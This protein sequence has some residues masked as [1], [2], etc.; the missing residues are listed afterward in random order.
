MEEISVLVVDD[1]RAHL[2]WISTTLGS[3][4]NRQNEYKLSIDTRYDA[5]LV[6]EEIDKGDFP[7]GIVIADVMMP[8]AKDGAFLIY[9]ALKRNRERYPDTF[10]MSITTERNTMSGVPEWR[11]ID[12]EQRI[13]G[14]EAWHI[15]FA[16]ADYFS[17]NDHSCLY[18]KDRWIYILYDAVTKYNNTLWRKSFL[19]ET[20]YTN[21]TST[22]WRELIYEAQ[23]IANENE[24]VV[25]LTGKPGV[26]REYLAKII[27]KS[28]KQWSAGGFV[29][30]NVASLPL[31]FVEDNLFGASGDFTVPSLL[32]SAAGGTLYLGNVNCDNESASVIRNVVDRVRNSQ[33]MQDGLPGAVILSTS[34][35]KELPDPLRNMRVCLIE[36]PALDDRREEIPELVQHINNE[37]AA[38]GIGDNIHFSKEVLDLLKDSHFERN[39]NDIHKTVETLRRNKTIDELVTFEDLLKH[40]K[41]YVD[42][43]AGVAKTSFSPPLAEEPHIDYKLRRLMKSVAPESEVD[44]RALY[45]K[46]NGILKHMAIDHYYGG[47]QE[48]LDS[49]DQGDINKLKKFTNAIKL[50]IKALQDQGLLLDLEFNSGNPYNKKKI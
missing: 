1:D 13:M 34:S 25:L 9:Q 20:L 11:S 10:L 18:D 14:E 26:G 15:S 16:K 47:K 49:S 24:K 31:K 33:G 7:F 50:N 37:L 43:P 45:N 4:C 29:H 27:H 6:A 28:S 21:I 30:F 23:K 41:D 40:C 2:S 46:N 32:K 39:I 12:D 17:S 22:C 5:R 38:K 44:L 36:I 3:Y 19:C 48:F 42:L 35:M 8:N